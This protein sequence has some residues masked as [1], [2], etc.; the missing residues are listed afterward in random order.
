MQPLFPS[1]YANLNS[2]EYFQII[3]RRRN[4]THAVVVVHHENEQ[5]IR[6]W[7]KF[8]TQCFV[9]SWENYLKLLGHPIEQLFPVHLSI[10]TEYDLSAKNCRP[11]KRILQH[12]E[13]T[14]V[15]VRVCVQFVLH[16]LK[17][18]FIY[19]CTLLIQKRCFLVFV[20]FKQTLRNVVYTR[21]CTW[22][23]AWAYACIGECTWVHASADM[24][25]V[26]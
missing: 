9:G 5:S 20:F 24:L 14:S 13:C 12:F 8:W 25:H 7:I 22:V 2:Y 15:S 11:H 23:Y 26:C 10:C 17:L 1:S 21:V 4:E 16:F 6:F 3:W 19:Q 18:V